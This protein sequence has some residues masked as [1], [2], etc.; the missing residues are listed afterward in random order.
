MIKTGDA[1]WGKK[2]VDGEEKEGRLGARAFFTFK[3]QWQELR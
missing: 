1:P 3:V 2:V